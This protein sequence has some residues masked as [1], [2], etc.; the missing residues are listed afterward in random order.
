[1]ISADVQRPHAASWELNVKANIVTVVVYLSGSVSEATSGFGR[2]FITFTICPHYC[3]VHYR[4]NDGP[5]DQPEPR[6][7]ALCH[8]LWIL[9]EPQD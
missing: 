5:G 3:C 1:M 7:H 6:A 4:V 2:R 8:R 9:W